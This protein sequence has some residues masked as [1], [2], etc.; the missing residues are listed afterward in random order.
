MTRCL[1]HFPILVLPMLLIL[2]SLS[3]CS[4]SH[5]SHTPVT[6]NPFSVAP[7][8]TDST[9][10]V[11][12]WNLEHFAKVGNATVD[13]VVNVVEGL[14]VDVVALQE[15]E[16]ANL[17]Q[18]VVDNLDGWDGYRPSSAYGGMNL[19]YIYRTDGLMEVTATYEILAGES[20]PL[21]R[22]P[23]VLEGTIGGQP[24][25]II[26]NHFKCCGDGQLDT[27]DDWDE[28]NRRYDAC[29]L[30]EQYV[31]NHFADRRVIIVGDFNDELAD[32]AEHNVFQNF[33]AQPDQ[34]LFTDLPIAQNEGDLW[35]FPSWPSHLDHILINSNTFEDF[36]ATE[37]LVGVMPLQSYLSGGWSEY[38]AEISDHLPVL[39]RF[40]PQPSDNP[41]MGA[42]IG[43]SGTLEVATWNL[44]NFGDGPQETGLVA[45]AIEALDVDVIA[46]QEVVSAAQF[47][48][49]KASLPNWDG[50]LGTGATADI[51]LAVLYRTGGTLDNVTV[52]ELFPDNNVEFI[53]A[54]LML[55]ATFQGDSFVVVNVH[56]KCCGD[57]VIDESEMWDE[58]NRR[59]QA[60][61]LLKDYLAENH[62]SDRVFLVGDF[63][64]QLDDQ[65]ADNIF[66]DFLLE[67]EQWEFADMDIA[68]GSSVG[69]SMPG[70]PAHVDHIL[71]SD[72][73]FPALAGS[74][75]EVEVS[76][77]HE[78]VDG[79]WGQY[80]SAISDH[81]PVVVKLEF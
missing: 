57:G 20:R 75:F 45:Q 31:N 78:Y 69:W 74:S 59:L 65:L 15:I 26:N 42:R 41:F 32:P 61:L 24:Y 46:L 81:L 13:H 71:V 64:D 68:I 50:V 63:N 48:A 43:T 55:E 54:P 38:D 17:F 67:P 27:G 25:V 29:Q 52:T 49:L 60:N 35:S 80:Y 30:L 22:R 79:N 53:R 77:L 28:E 14:D 18:R 73:V 58:E 7:V 34:W 4:D 5:K 62:G 51:N 47:E 10:E 9:L 16:S 11:M 6:D 12:T 1:K 19:A 3:S 72:E 33:L 2:V 56:H 36:A 23:L 37:A 76:P 40:M 66:M 8:G 70:L 21:P 44:G 39:A